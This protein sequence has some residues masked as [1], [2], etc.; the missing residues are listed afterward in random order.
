MP[1]D[2]SIL[3]RGARAPDRIIAYGADPVQIV[4]V[5][6]G[7]AGAGQR[8][9]VLI[10]HGGFWRPDIDRVHARPMADAIAAAGWTVA[11]PEYSRVALNPAPTLADLTLVLRHA[12]DRVG[13]HNGSVLL[14]GHSAGG[15]LALWA[16]AARL[17]A[18]LI[19]TVALAPVA[20][21]L[22]AAELGLGTGAVSRFLGADPVSR[23]D[24]DPRQMAAPM[25]GTTLIHGIDD[26]IVPMVVSESYVAAH[27]SVRLI[28][29][30]GA[31]HFGLI[32]PQSA[33]WPTVMAQL[34]R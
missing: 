18:P 23:P 2:E 6:R 24:I 30:A 11:L 34:A 5:R 27:P 7:V 31:G 10:I 16:S 22:L 14:L 1:E 33:V 13:D 21:L 20:D 17:C 28:R 4:E 32:D 15:H 25:T 8:P 29:V 12:A 19:G 9:L 3:S 26:E